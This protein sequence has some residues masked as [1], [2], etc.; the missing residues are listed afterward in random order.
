MRWVML[1]LALALPTALPT[2][3]EADP[4]QFLLDADDTEL[5]SSFIHHCL[6][7]DGKLGVMLTFEQHL[8]LLN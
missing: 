1:L 5:Q 8:L 6:V 4:H 2:A 3:L 7:V